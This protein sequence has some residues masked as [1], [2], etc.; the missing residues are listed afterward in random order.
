MVKYLINISL[1]LVIGIVVG[2][3]VWF[4]AESGIIAIGVGVITGSVL[5]LSCFMEPK[6]SHRSTDRSKSQRIS[7]FN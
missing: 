7:S 2:L 5:S 3:V 4:V 6:K 1:G